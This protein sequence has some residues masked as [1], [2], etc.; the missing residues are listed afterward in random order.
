MGF[1]K[2]LPSWIFFR[3]L[4]SKHWYVNMSGVPDLY[5][6]TTGAMTELVTAIVFCQL[7]FLDGYLFVRVVFRSEHGSCGGDSVR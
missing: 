7:K 6:C 4:E 1:R 2:C 3:V 5:I